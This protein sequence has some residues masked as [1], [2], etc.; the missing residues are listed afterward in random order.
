MT[1]KRKLIEYEQDL[2]SDSIF[3]EESRVFLMALKDVLASINASKEFYVRSNA[4]L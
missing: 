4:L 2:H 1:K 3:N